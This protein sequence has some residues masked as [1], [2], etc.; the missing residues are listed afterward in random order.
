LARRA[1]L[2]VAAKYLLFQLPGFAI[3]AGLAYAAH[4]WLGLRGEL[5]LAAV[6]LWALKDAVLFPFV[7]HA[8]EVETRPAAAG[9]LGAHGIAEDA[10]APE[11]YVRVGP[12][13]WR[14]RLA[15]GAAPVAP[16]GGVR[17]EAVEGLTLRVRGDGDAGL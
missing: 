6:A 3:V 16:G 8:Y 9:L 17:V 14:A 2:L 11:G 13:R 10:I 15:A 1:G 4:R 12:E 7:R 5:A